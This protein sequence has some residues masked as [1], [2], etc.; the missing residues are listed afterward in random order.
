MV[1]I[2]LLSFIFFYRF[3]YKYISNIYICFSV[4]LSVFVRVCV[5]HL[6]G[7]CLIFLFVFAIFFLGFFLFNYKNWIGV[8]SFNKDIKKNAN[9]LHVS[10]LETYKEQCN[11]NI[12]T[13]IKGETQEK[14]RIVRRD[15]Y[16]MTRLLKKKKE[17]LFK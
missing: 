9:L 12:N 13:E 8:D 14:A 5:N 6:K 15:P 1:T 11:S 17:I 3:I 10:S 4:G 16:E 2:V 7:V